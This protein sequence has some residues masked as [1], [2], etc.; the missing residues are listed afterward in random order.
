MAPVPLPQFVAEAPAHLSIRQYSDLCHTVHAQYPMPKWHYAWA[1]VHV[2]NP[3]TVLP[4]HMA[5]IV[6]EAS[7]GSSPTIGVGAYSEGC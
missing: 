2:R 3:V 6:R 5:S 1:L 4:R 7:N